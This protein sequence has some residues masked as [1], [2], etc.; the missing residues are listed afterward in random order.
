MSVEIL[1]QLATDLTKL[2]TEP[3]GSRRVKIGENNSPIPQDR[4]F[5]MYNHFHNAYEFSEGIF[6]PTPRTTQ[7]HIDRF[8]L[9]VEKTFLDEWWSVELRVP[10]VAAL[11]VEGETFAARGGNWGN[12]AVIVKRLLYEGEFVALAAGVGLDLPTGSD[13]ESRVGS[14]VLKFDIDALHVLPYL[15]AVVDAGGG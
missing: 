15:G 3:V 7:E 1:D 5:A 6:S 10:V 4:M 9:G 8:T 13:F 11:D 12:Q 14:G 2:L